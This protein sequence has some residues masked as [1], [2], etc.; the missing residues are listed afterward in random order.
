MGNQTFKLA[1]VGN[2][3]RG[4]DARKASR[5]IAGSFEGVV[6]SERFSDGLEWNSIALGSFKSFLD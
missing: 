6:E 2:F 1:F 4:V 5:R 3:E